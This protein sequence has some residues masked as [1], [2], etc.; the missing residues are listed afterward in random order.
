MDTA[1]T[2]P[3][4]RC[5]WHDHRRHGTI[6]ATMPPNP[7]LHHAEMLA[8]RLRKTWQH[9]HRQMERQGFGAFRL[10]DRDIPEIRLCVDWYEG[11]LAVAEYARTQ[12]LQWPGWLDAMAKAAGAALGVRP[13]W[14]ATKQRQTRPQ[15]GD[16]YRAINERGERFPVREGGLLFLVNLHDRLDVGLFLDHRLTRARV[17]SEASGKRVLN[18]YAYTGSFTV[19]AAH[20][21]A[22]QTTTVDAS[23]RA[24]AWADDNLRWNG[25]DGP[26]HERVQA[27]T[28]A[29]LH[30]AARQERLWD[31][32]V[33]DPPSFSERMD[34]PPFDV[35]RD[36]VRLLRAVL[37]VLAPGGVV[38]FSTNHQRFQ[39][40]LAELDGARCDEITAKTV[41]PD[42]RNRQVHRCWRIAASP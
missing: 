25:L 21:G 11:R 5:H 37:A 27:D 42:F 41:P 20:G 28:L 19:Y 15:H 22:A 32:C 23:A 24:L 26:Q 35:Q 33:V 1:S 16:R 39:P 4:P 18:L 13:D 17:R 38:Y 40:R 8:N 6:P 29:F 12:T 10:Y 2:P 36:H 3:R 34:A 31:L 14:I 9:L 7:T 30:A